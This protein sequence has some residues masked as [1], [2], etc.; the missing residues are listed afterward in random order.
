MQDWKNKIRALERS[1]W[2]HAA[3]PGSNPA[4]TPTSPA[5]VFSIHWKL[6]DD[7]QHHHHHL[8]LADSQLLLPQSNISLSGSAMRCSCCCCLRLAV[9]GTSICCIVRHCPVTSTAPVMSHTAESTHRSTSDHMMCWGWFG[10]T[11][12]AGPL[13]HCCVQVSVAGP[14]MLVQRV[15]LYRSGT[16]GDN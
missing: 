16:P 10:E 13:T 7:H 5:R 12:V 4:V 8:L 2:L 11:P 3:R 15:V 1:W 9:V 14:H 6:E